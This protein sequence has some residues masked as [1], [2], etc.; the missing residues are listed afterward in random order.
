M[1]PENLW[2]LLATLAAANAMRPPSFNFYRRGDDDHSWGRRKLLVP[3][4]VLAVPCFAG[5][6]QILERAQRRVLSGSGIPIDAY[7][8]DFSGHWRLD[9]SENFDEYLK[10]LNVSATHR[11]FA[12]RASIEHLIRRRPEKDQATYEMCVVN[13]LG[14]KCEVFRVGNEPT[15][16]ASSDARGDPVTKKIDW[17]DSGKRVLVTQV[18]SVAGRLVDKRK[19]N[20]PDEMVMELISPTNVVAY[21][22]FRRVPDEEFDSKK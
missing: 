17:E 1:I 6:R 2:H 14:Q 10:S 12:V 19:L 8:V 9:R 15:V 16:I 22:I 5:S 13:R 4:G 11:G 3:V 21:R 20:N 7:G 18:D